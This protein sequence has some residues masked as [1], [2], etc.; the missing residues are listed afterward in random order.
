MSD[1]CDPVDCSPIGPLSK[2]F[3]RQ[4]HWSGCHSLLQGIFPTHGSNPGLLRYRQILYQPSYKGSPM[5]ARGKVNKGSV[6]LIHRSRG[7]FCNTP[8]C[9]LIPVQLQTC[10]RQLGLTATK[11]AVRSRH[12]E[13]DWLENH[14]H[15]SRSVARTFQNP[16]SVTDLSHECML[17]PCTRV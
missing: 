17:S 10:S 15:I 13:G 3:S 16:Q 4:E 2:G 9:L 11:S 5:V 8:W 14:G 1:A 6:G 12:R 7:P